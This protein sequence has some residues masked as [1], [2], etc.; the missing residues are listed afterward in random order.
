MLVGAALGPV[1]STCSPTYFVILATVLPVDFLLGTAYLLTSLAG[2]ALVLGLIAFFRQKLTDKLQIAA[3]SH[4][5]FKKGM[6]LLFI[7]VRLFIMTGLDKKLETAVLDS[8][9]CDITKVE[10]KILDSVRTPDKEL[11]LNTV[12]RTDAP[13]ST[14][15]TFGVSGS[16]LE[17]N[18]IMYDRAT[19]NL[20]Q[21]STGE[22]LAGS[23]YGEQLAIVEFQLLTMD[24]VRE[25]YPTAQ[26]LST[27]TEYERD[28][29]RNPYAGYDTNDRFIFDP[30]SLDT[31]P[32]HQNNHCGI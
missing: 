11:K 22:V 17:S 12:S 8:G 25:K 6:G 16:L 5:L 30:S 20:W 18:M 1:F 3:D 28:Y 31:K 32:F 24:V 23:F 15:S 7:L 29:E 26:V 19:E 13:N 2:L 4:G 9:Y 21:Q 14:V 27:H 10:Q